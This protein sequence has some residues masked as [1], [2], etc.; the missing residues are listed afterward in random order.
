MTAK[1][2]TIEEEL[3]GATKVPPK[4]KSESR[5]R[6]LSRLCRATTD[7]DNDEW[8][9]LS[10]PAQ[11]WVNK[12]VDAMT[13]HTEIEDPSSDGPATEEAEPE[14]GEPEEALEEVAEDFSPTE[15]PKDE[16][17]PNTETDNLPEGSTPEEIAKIQEPEPIEEPPK[18]KRGRPKKI[19]LPE[20]ETPE[21]AVPAKRKPGRP[22]KN[23]EVQEAGPAAKKEPIIPPPKAKTEIPPELKSKTQIKPEL[24]VPIKVQPEDGDRK[25]FVVR[26]RRNSKP[27]ASDFFRELCID[28]PTWDRGAL[29]AKALK[30]GYPIQPGTA[31]VIYYEMKKILEIL[32]EK[33]II[34]FEV[35]GK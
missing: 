26:S 7:L 1:T 6:F 20:T 12:A 23:I 4:A 10:K 18:R 9:R 21:A 17:D 15:D 31:N 11:R 16:D 5:S 22:K 8:G 19:R 24:K 25:R 14:A 28:N 33:G 29:M 32:A 2:M 35:E 3:L 13:A 27:G 34:N 30:S